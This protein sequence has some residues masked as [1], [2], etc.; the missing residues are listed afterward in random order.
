MKI[1]KIFRSDHEHEPHTH[2]YDLCL[3]ITFTH[4][5]QSLHL[6]FHWKIRRFAANTANSKQGTAFFLHKW[7]SSIQ[8]VHAYIDTRA[9][10]TNTARSTYETMLDARFMHSNLSSICARVKIS[11]KKKLNLIIPSET[12]SVSMPVQFLSRSQKNNRSRS[13]HQSWVIHISE[14][15][16]IFA[17]TSRTQCVRNVG[18]PVFLIPQNAFD[19]F[20]ASNESDWWSVV[21]ESI[22]CVNKII[23]FLVGNLLIKTTTRHR[24]HATSSLLFIWLD[25]NSLCVNIWFREAFNWKQWSERCFVIYWNRWIYCDN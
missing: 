2:D 11:R 7:S 19:S 4:L 9:L 18:C 24:V 15:S 17:S 10:H 6:Y 5:D 16:F 21:N 14:D 1:E 12:R 3:S 20:C 8:W 23:F 22:P 25:V 13:S